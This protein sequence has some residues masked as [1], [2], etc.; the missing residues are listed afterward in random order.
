MG[1]S[2]YGTVCDIDCWWYGGRQEMSVANF[3]VWRIQRIAGCDKELRKVDKFYYSW[4][5]YI[6]RSHQQYFLKFILNLIFNIFFNICCMTHFCL[7]KEIVCISTCF[8]METQNISQNRESASVRPSL[9]FIIHLIL[10][11]R[12]LLQWHFSFRQI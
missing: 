12:H 1:V 11:I 2:Y 8:S 7:T 6:K 5:N 3:I 9:P 4:Q 10:G